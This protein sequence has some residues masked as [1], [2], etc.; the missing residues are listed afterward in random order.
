MWWLVP[1]RLIWATSATF[2]QL[3]EFKAKY[4][5]FRCIS[6]FEK[7]G[8]TETSRKT[9]QDTIEE[10]MPC[11]LKTAS[12][13]LSRSDLLKTV[14]E[15]KSEAKLL[16]L[17][18]YYPSKHGFEL[19]DV[20]TSKHQDDIDKATASTDI[21]TSSKQGSFVVFFSS[22]AENVPKVKKTWDENRYFGKNRHK[23]CC[24]ACIGEA[25]VCWKSLERVWW[26]CLS[27]LMW[28]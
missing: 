7:I 17:D 22:K 6:C 8:I 23:R 5:L 10:I 24:K 11:A 15:L 4:F 14:S 20:T 28:W 12:D 16:K 1:Q 26:G 21:M 19:K 27:S 9:I 13:E 3:L 25:W 2:I 18:R